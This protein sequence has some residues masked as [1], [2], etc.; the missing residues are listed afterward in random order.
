MNEKTKEEL[1]DKIRDKIRDKVVSKEKEAE[2]KLTKFVKKIFNKNFSLSLINFIL[3]NY[4]FVFLALIQN[5]DYKI[6]KFNKKE[7]LTDNSGGLSLISGEVQFKGG[8]VTNRK[9]LIKSG[10]VEGN[11][12]DNINNVKN[13]KNADNINNVKNA[14]NADNINNANNDSNNDTT[15]TQNLNK[16]PKRKLRIYVTNRWFYGNFAPYYSTGGVSSAD[17]ACNDPNETAKPVGKAK[18][19]ALIGVTGVR[20]ICVK[21]FCE[22]NNI[23]IDS[24]LQP[25]TSYVRSDGVTP[26][27]VTNEAGIFVDNLSNS[28]DDAS[29]SSYIKVYWTGLKRDWT[30]ND[31]A[32]CQN[33]STNSPS[34]RGSSSDTTNSTINNDVHNIIE[35]VD[36]QCSVRNNLICVEQN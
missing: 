14:K 22:K 3:L 33:F 11:N 1:K 32:N 13:A 30:V 36:I 31:N 9:G 5:C 16:K 10:D 29:G 34:Q 24:P 20:V 19:K 8:K 27:G 7:F 15:Y 2:D 28:F 18:Y 4:I 35:S 26:I 25:N 12:A 21:S 23:P 6:N 17:K